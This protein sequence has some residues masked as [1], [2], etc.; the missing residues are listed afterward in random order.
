MPE[1]RH[2]QVSGQPVRSG[3]SVQPR[4]G[5]GTTLKQFV[6]WVLIKN[7][8]SASRKSM[9][10]LV[11]VWEKSKIRL[12]LWYL[13]NSWNSFFATNIKPLVAYAL[14]YEWKFQTICHL[15]KANIQLMHSCL[16]HR[17]NIWKIIIPYKDDFWRLLPRIGWWDCGLSAGADGRQAEDSQS[18]S[19]R[20]GKWSN[21]YFI[22]V[23]LI[24]YVYFAIQ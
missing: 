4:E 16:K 24:N 2:R 14:L 1:H 11:T 9:W 3:R 10:C 12:A 19:I 22:I 7:F 20:E 21:H 15:Y 13:L 23:Y 6:P 17:N 8:Y 18:W 5:S